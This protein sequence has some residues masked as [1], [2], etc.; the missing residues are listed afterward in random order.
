MRIERVADFQAAMLQ[1][2]TPFEMGRDLAS[3]LSEH[4]R[5]AQAELGSDAEQRSLELA[6]FDRLL[7]SVNM[8]DV[9]R[10]VIDK[11]VL[12]PAAAAVAT[13]LDGDSRAQLALTT[14][15]RETYRTLGLYRQA[16]EQVESELALLA[17]VEGSDHRDALAAGLALCD[18]HYQLGRTD[19]A[20][21][22]LPLGALGDPEARPPHVQQAGLVA[23]FERGVRL[24]F[25]IQG[26]CGL[27]IG[28]I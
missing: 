27:H 17:A 14:T 3:D 13:E 8:T 1:R 6:S 9:A 20:Q 16:K 23:R 5:A 21:E 25:S 7:A 26:A 11:N 2:V 22:L 19:E 28:D 18:L 24:G 10:R 4:V 15:L 12:G